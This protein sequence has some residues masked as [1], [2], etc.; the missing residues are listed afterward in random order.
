MSSIRENNKLVNVKQ[1]ELTQVRAD[2][3]N[4][5]SILLY[6]QFNSLLIVHSMLLFLFVSAVADIF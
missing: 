3:Q 2:L 5:L 1:Q 4:I 6:V